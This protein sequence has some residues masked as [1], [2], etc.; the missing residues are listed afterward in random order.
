MN[1]GCVYYFK[2]GF[3][4]AKD[5]FSKD[6]KNYLKYYLFLI[7]SLI[8]RLSIVTMPIFNLANV[9]LIRNVKKNR[10]VELLN[11]FE[12]A[13]NPKK[14]WRTLV[15]NSLWL[16]IVFAGVVIII[17]CAVQT[18]PFLMSIQTSPIVYTVFALLILIVTTIVITVY[19]LL[20]SLYFLPVNYILDQYPDLSSS[21]VLKTSFSSMSKDGKGTYIGIA[22][23][24]YL[25]SFAFSIVMF[26]FIFIAV[27][28]GSIAG[29]KGVV[30]FVSIMSGLI[31]ILYLLLLPFLSLSQEV[32]VQLL[33]DDVVQK[34]VSE[35][36]NGN[37]S[38][39]QPVLNHV[40]DESKELSSEE[41]LDSLFAEEDKEESADDGLKDLSDEELLDSLFADIN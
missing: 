28:I 2:E 24:F 13:E 25:L 23:L 21:M 9:R 32:A 29:M 30:I 18:I 26:I 38:N 39:N 10:N 33:F 37:E 6:K 40:N 5:T 27:L 35:E 36:D 1:K 16:T 34:P 19:S 12:G 15:T 11:S 20:A 3:K 8:G 22:F 17:L 41:L 14:W 31:G 7:A 4:I